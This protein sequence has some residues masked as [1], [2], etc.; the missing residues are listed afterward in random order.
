MKTLVSAL[1]L[2]VLAFVPARAA[3]VQQLQADLPRHFA[4]T[5]AW[6]S[7]SDIQRVSVTLDDVTAE[8]SRVTARGK[9]TY[10]VG[11]KPTHIMVTWSID[12]ATLRFEMWEQAPQAKPSDNFVTDGSHVGMISKD[13][14]LITATWT[15]R[16]SGQRGTLQLEAR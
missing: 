12:A 14:K 8:G 13:L 11:D 16:G 1:L 10:L 3:D 2:V 6:D 7:G 15:T 5:F 9:G 4:G